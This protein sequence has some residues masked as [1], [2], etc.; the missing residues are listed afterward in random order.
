VKLTDQ[1]RR[2]EP[3]PYAVTPGEPAGRFGL[4]LAQPTRL[5]HPKGGEAQTRDKANSKQTEH[6]HHNRREHRMKRII[7]AALLAAALTGTAAQATSPGKWSRFNATRTT[8]QIVRIAVKTRCL[9]GEDSAAHL[10]EISYGGGKLVLG[11]YKR[12]Y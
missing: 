4:N 7:A 9:N 3:S 10:K 8:S 11:C 1:R 6:R 12:G 5:A 2:G